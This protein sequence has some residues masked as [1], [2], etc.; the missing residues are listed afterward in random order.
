MVWICFLAGRTDTTPSTTLAAPPA[1]CWDSSSSVSGRS[2]PA[3]RTDSPASNPPAT[4]NQVPPGLPPKNAWSNGPSL[5]VRTLNNSVQSF[6]SPTSTKSSAS[7]VPN[8]VINSSADNYWSTSPPTS[9]PDT[10][11]SCNNVPGNSDMV[12]VQISDSFEEEFYGMNIKEFGADQDDG[13][14]ELD[15][16]APGSWG[17]ASL[18]QPWPAA[19]TSGWDDAPQDAESYW[20]ESQKAPEKELCSVHGVLCKKGICQESAKKDWARKRAEAEKE[21]EA[22][23][24]KK[25]NRGKRPAT[26]GALGRGGPLAATNA[27]SSPFRG[28]G[29]PVRTN[30]RGAPRAIVSPAAME[31]RD[32]AA[33]S[34]ASPTSGWGDDDASDEPNADVKNPAA[35][36]TSN[37]G[38]NVSEAGFDPWASSA[39]PAMQTKG[40]DRGKGKNATNQKK[41]TP[42]KPMTWA[43]QM[44]AASAGENDDLSSVMS[45]KSSKRRGPKS[46]DAKS[47]TSGWGNVSEMHW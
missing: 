45:S 3:C 2:T 13:L 40:K 5:Q 15:S 12:H 11:P 34:E 32:A 41:S 38:W 14:A 27:Q 37:D 1:D 24:G 46:E 7:S 43:E 9:S 20:K 26:R 36:A 8:R 25:D 23:K 33:R 42:K 18:T 35:D 28:S 30:W 19:D 17:A 21:R 16:I 10:E 47:S 39:A 4:A 44:D 22:E 29:A 6:A 31:Q